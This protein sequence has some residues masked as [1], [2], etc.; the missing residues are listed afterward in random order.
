MRKR[1]GTMIL[2]R[3]LDEVLRKSEGEEMET[4]AEESRSRGMIVGLIKRNAL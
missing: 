2:A 3:L 4:L 1:R